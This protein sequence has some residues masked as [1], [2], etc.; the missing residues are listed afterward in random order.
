MSNT[1]RRALVILA[2]IGVGIAATLW[3]P[4][5]EWNQ[6]LADWGQTAGPFGALLA[7]L[8]FIPVCIFMLP[9]TA[10]T[11]AIA[12][13]FGMGPAIL[14]VE[15]GAVLGA[16]A[17]FLIGRHFARDI[18][19]RNSAKHPLLG[20]LDRVL[21]ERSFGM[22]FLIRLS[23]LFPYAL[24]GYAMGA[25]RANFWRHQL[26]TA[27][28]IL[29]Q[30]TVTCWIGASVAD[31]SRDLGTERA[32]APAEY[33]LFGIGIIAALVVLAVIARRTKAALTEK[34][35]PGC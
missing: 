32:K 34:L 24:V 28:A 7:G 6:A 20:A 29:P 13:A 27:A 3:L 35:E 10:L 26:A 21:D 5:G 31:L 2:L 33:A 16:A 8:L 19:V 14:G 25:S 22:L 11:Y 30:V 23:P 15:V 17:V 4:L 1:V 18:V 9:A 12:F